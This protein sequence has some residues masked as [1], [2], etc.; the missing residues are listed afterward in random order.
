MKLSLKE[1]LKLIDEDFC[2]DSKKLVLLYEA[3]KT[4]SSKFFLADSASVT[5]LENRAERPITTTEGQVA[6]VI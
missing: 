3:C 5:V 2:M 1:N 6:M 4:V